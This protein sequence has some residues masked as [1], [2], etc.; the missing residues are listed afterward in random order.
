MPRRV[1]VEIL[2]LEFLVAAD[3]PE[4]ETQWI[5]NLLRKKRFL[6]QI[7]EAIKQ[8]L[9]R[10]RRLHAVSLRMTF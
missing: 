10:R 2:R 5:S 9:K 6:R 1:T 4:A 7:R 8:I 3:L